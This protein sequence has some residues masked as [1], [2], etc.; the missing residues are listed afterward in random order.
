MQASK[1]VKVKPNS[2]QISVAA[3]AIAAAQFARCGYD[4][5]VQYGANQPGYDLIV[6]DQND[7]LLKISVKGSQDGAWALAQ[8]FLT[9]ANYQTAI[10]SWLAKQNAA[11]MFCFVQ[12]Y[13][14]E[15]GALPRV[16]LASA[17]EVAEALRTAKNGRG[18]VALYENYTFTRGPHAGC[19]D[20]LPLGWIFSAE[21]IQ[22]LLANGDLALTAE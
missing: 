15:I 8:N 6:A 20:K 10:D 9:N 12:F 3:E 18:E 13:R 21:R 4:V 2:H 1:P 22:Q 17:H 5:S 19:T 14:V 11:V 16:Y 7:H